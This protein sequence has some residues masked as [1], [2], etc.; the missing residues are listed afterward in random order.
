MRAG[1]NV[2]VFRQILVDLRKLGAQSRAEGRQR[3]ASVDECHKDSLALQI[4][5]MELLAVLISQLEIGDL[6]A[7]LQRVGRSGSFSRTAVGNADIVQPVV[8]SIA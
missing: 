6:L 2:W 8:A 5:Q 7:G 4:G 3:A 1:I